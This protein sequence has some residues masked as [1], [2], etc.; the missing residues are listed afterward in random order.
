[1]FWLSNLV[2]ATKEQ[3]E[4][5]QILVRQNRI[6][7]GCQFAVQYEL[8]SCLRGLHVCTIHNQDV[9]AARRVVGKSNVDIPDRG[10]RLALVDVGVQRSE[11]RDVQGLLP[12]PPINTKFP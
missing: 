12:G 5:V 2:H 4:G 7:G 8:N 6:D 3:F 1:M 9:A 10:T 11:M